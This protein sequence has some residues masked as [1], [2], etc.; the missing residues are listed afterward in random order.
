MSHVDLESLWYINRH[1]IKVCTKFEQNRANPGRSIDNF[2]NFLHVI[3]H[4]DLDL[5]PF[6]LELLQH[7]GCHGFKL[8]TKIEW[9]RTIH[10]WVID[11]L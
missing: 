2:A 7:F 4:R 5:W 6:D 11:D 1:V 3:S 9:N 10:G 8:C